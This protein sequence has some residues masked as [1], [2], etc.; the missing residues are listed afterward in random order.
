M[1][2]FVSYSLN[3]PA[4]TLHAG[5]QPLVRRLSQLAAT[6]YLLFSF[7]NWVPAAE[8]PGAGSNGDKTNAPPAEKKEDSKKEEGKTT[9][10]VIPDAARKPVLVTNT[11]TIAGKAVT[12]VAETAMLPL[13]K[14]DG[15]PR[16]SVFYIAYTSLTETNAATRPITFCFNGGPG[17]SSAWLHLGALGPRRAR[18]N[19][20]GTLPKPP[21]SLVDNEYSL[22][23]ASDLVFIDPVATGFSRPAKDEKPEQFFGQSGDI[24]SVGEFIRLW[25]TRHQRWLS[26]KFLCGESY[27]VFRAAG[28]AEHLASRYGMYLNGVILVSGVLDFATLNEGHGNDLAALAFLPAFTATAHYHKKLPPDLQAD[29]RKALDEARSF[30]R[31][32]YPQALLQGAALPAA[33]RARTVAKLARLTGLPAKV[34]EDRDLRVSSTAFRKLLLQDQGLI[35]GRY[36]ARITGHDADPASPYPHF[37]PSDVAVKGPFS[38]GMNAYLRGELKFEDDLPYEMLAGVGPWNFD[39]RN[40]FPSVASSLASVIN[41]NPYLRVLVLGGLRDLAC[42]IDGIRHTLDH[43]QID[44]SCRRNITF[45]EFEAGHMMYI[46]LPDLKKLQHELDGFVGQ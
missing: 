39:N 31:T 37:D 43:L 16:A 36:D 8:P 41:E 12:Y 29:L 32:E 20:D 3:S 4:V 6:C 15:N 10:A 19:E 27:G 22:L 9:V 45:A 17:S 1:S 25:A 28:L 34:I 26:P 7:A 30:A 11:I 33:D 13:L 5:S 40:S 14:A 2:D 38:A 24:E 44:P 23:H 21:F 46:N 18:M 42:P 35:L